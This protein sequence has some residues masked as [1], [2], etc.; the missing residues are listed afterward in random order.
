MAVQYGNDAIDA[1][2][3]AD[4]LVNCTSAGMYPDTDIS[5]VPADWLHSGLFVYDQVYNPTET[6][7]VKIAKQ[8]GASGVNG[9][10]MLVYQGALSFKIWTGYDAPINTMKTALL[11][12]LQAAAK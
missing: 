3:E 9:Q 12:G 11:Q 5:P 8:A 7:L 6:K 2:A 4:L 1:I 10:G